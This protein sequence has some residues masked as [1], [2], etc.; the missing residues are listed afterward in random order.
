[1]L[2]EEQPDWQDTNLAL[3]GS[4]IEKNIKKAA[5]DGEPQWDG[6]G[7]KVGLQMWRI[8]Q[9]KV[10]PWSKPGKFHT[11]DS[12][13]ILNTY[14]P[15]PKNLPD[16]LAWDIFFWIGK[17]SSQDE[18]GTAA[19]KTV[20][21]DHKLG[22]AAIQHR[23]TQENETKE[24]LNLF[25][26]TGVTYLAGGVKSGF[27]HVEEEKFNPVLLHVKGVRGA[28]IL[29]E[30]EKR[31][32]SMNSG[33]VFILDTGSVVYQWNGKT[34]NIQEK[35]KAQEVCHG[36]Q[37]GRQDGTKIVVL[38]DGQDRD[39]KEFW[40]HIP[41]EWTLFG[42]IT[43]KKYNMK[44]EEEGGID[45]EVKAFRAVLYKLS[46]S[47]GSLKF[48]KI[49]SGDKNN[50]FKR[51]YLNS[52]DV[53]ILDDGFKVFVWVGNAASSSEKGQAFMYAHQY[54]KNNKRPQVL[55]IIRLTEGKETATF[56]ERFVP[57]APSSSCII[58]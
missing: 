45:V 26:G 12:Y 58:S 27:K 46:D 53:F 1:M 11:G 41:G 50:Q 43:L 14:H 40:D 39:V 20:E 24:F 7:E 17:E 21:L 57:G 33:D 42:L 10:K 37:S 36:I 2:K 23:E 35:M 5:A 6:A 34:S 3:F 16:K 38:E 9:F 30:V 51:G 56:N 32:D 54:L 25:S 49:V 4:D 48:K 47:S 15:D 44:S 19:Y 28:V 55:P 8:E 52:K 31:K 29:K 22:D 13:I 18:Y